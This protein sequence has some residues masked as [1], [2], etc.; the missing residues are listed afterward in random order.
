MKKRGKIV[1]NIPLVLAVTGLG[2]AVK[3]IMDRD[4]EIDRLQNAT[5]T[6]AVEVPPEIKHQINQGKTLIYWVDDDGKKHYSTTENSLVK[7]L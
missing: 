6:I 7:N 5:D 2:F 3:A 4:D 1:R